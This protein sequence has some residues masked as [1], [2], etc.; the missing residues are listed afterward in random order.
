MGICWVVEQHKTGQHLLQQRAKCI[1]YTIAIWHGSDE[2]IGKYSND[3][4]TAFVK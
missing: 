3:A 4:F 2:Y 1:C